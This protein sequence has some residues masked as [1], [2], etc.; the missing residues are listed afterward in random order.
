M[1]DTDQSLYNLRYNQVTLGMEGFG[2]G[3]P[4]WTP[5]I[6]SADAVA[7][8]HADA[9]AN[10]TGNV[11]LVSGTNVTLSQTGQAITI[12]ASS[13]G[14]TTVASYSAT[15]VGAGTVTNSS[16]F[17][18]TNGATVEVWGTFQ[19][20]TPTAVP[21]TI[22]LPVAIFA[23]HLPTSFGLLGQIYFVDPSGV[24]N[25]SVFYDGSDTAHMYIG[26]Q[27]DDTSGN[28]APTKF[29]GSAVIDAGAYI[30]VR[31]SYPIA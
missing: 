6:L 27:S 21:F 16:F 7:S 24:A 4:M 22:S 14:G 3:S 30:G 11:Q 20:G 23:A 29:T 18:S 9:H 5:L 19:S 31:F 8:I 2:G 28:S 26:A 12:N 10:I 15:V 1:S 13:G 17:Y 25:I